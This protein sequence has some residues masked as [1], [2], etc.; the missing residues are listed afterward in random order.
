MLPQFDI[1]KKLLPGLLPLFV[2][3]A[4]DAIW[5]TQTGLLVALGF[6]LSELLFTW[7][8]EQR[9]D[10]FILADTALLLLLGGV[11]WISSND[12]FFKLKPAL[13]EAIF[14][15][16]LGISTFSSNNI[17]LMMSRR[18]MK[19]LTLNAQQLTQFQRNI[20]VLFWLFSA[21]T[22]L[23]VISAF[24]FSTELWA[25]ISGGL[26]YILFGSYLGVELLKNYRNKYKWKKEEWLPLVDTN[27]QI[28]GKA[29]RSVCHSSINYLH[30]V[31]HLHIFNSQGELYL[32]KRPENKLV[33]PGKWDTAVGGHIALN[34]A[35]ET[36]LARETKEELG[37]E[38]L[39]SKPLARYVWQSEIESELVY[40]FIALFDG[41]ITPDQQELDGGR[42]WSVQALESH[43]GKS[44][45][46]PNFE[47]EYQL[48]KRANHP[49]KKIVNE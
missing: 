10:R 41:P 26:L 5:G 36:G 34:E 7:I 21:H 42:F 45:F 16:L 25:F 1:L 48:L 32:Q 22:L 46:T 12:I 6:G 11:S 27:G 19:N 14:C 15:F 38:N 3:I 33:Q 13:I 4:A 37:L 23:I 47:Q 44:V 28:T 29:P 17:V 24:W 31:V 35:V 9:L 20:R 18:Y 2:F 30:P 8:K 40:V 39:N 49:F 43:L